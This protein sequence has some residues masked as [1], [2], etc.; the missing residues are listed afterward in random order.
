MKQFKKATVWMP[1]VTLLVY[2]LTVFVF[3]SWVLG[4]SGELFRFFTENGLYRLD[5]L[6][7]GFELD[8]AGFSDLPASFFKLLCQI[9][10]GIWHGC[11]GLTVLDVRLLSA[12]YV[13]LCVFAVWLIARNLRLRTTLSNVIAG[14]LVVVLALCYG[15][16]SY[17]NTFYREGAVLPLLLLVCAGVLEFSHHKNWWSFLLFFLS[18]ASLVTLG[19]VYALLAVPF[20]LIGIRLA[21]VSKKVFIRIGMILLSV[22]LLFFGLLGTQSLATS[23]VKESQ[24]NAVFYGALKDTD[25]L[26]G[27]RELGLSEE[28]SVYVNHPYFEVTDE[29][30]LDELFYPHFSY[31]QLAGYYLQHPQ[32]FWNVV[33]QAAN[34]VYETGISYLKCF[35][36]DILSPQ[37]IVSAPTRWYETLKLR[38]LP[39]GLMFWFVYLVLFIVL[40]CVRRKTLEDDGEKAVADCSIVFA[41]APLFTLFATPFCVGL[42]EISRRLFCCN[43][44][45][46]VFLVIFL[47]NAAEVILLRRKR[48]R[49]QYGVN[50]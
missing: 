15:M 9:I 25:D 14:L 38:F 48:L 49:D 16:F 31:S 17:F 30:K 34:N 19:P 3:P 41:F 20:L 27:L 23:D 46:E 50:Q 36:D 11:F 5:S 4:E 39:R 12:V 43:A 6:Q 45:F 1:A 2:V 32:V 33:K 29:T 26:S 42:T 24:Y 35:N 22:S 10:V 37:R 44:V 18:S 40:A 8:F 21:F 13:V 28:L 7:Y 47:V